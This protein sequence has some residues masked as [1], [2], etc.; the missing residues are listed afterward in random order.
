M[1][2]HLQT[3][4]GTATQ[5]HGDRFL[6][7]LMLPCLPDTRLETALIR[8]NLSA[9]SV[10]PTLLLHGTTSCLLYSSHP[11]D[12]TDSVHLGPRA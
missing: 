10:D 5:R 8:A 9:A 1:S 11:V 4:A 12:E 2:N 7:L 3:A 6:F